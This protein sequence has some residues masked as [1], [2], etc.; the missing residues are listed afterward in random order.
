MRCAV[1]FFS[2]KNRI[3]I[4]DIAKGLVKGI[5]S[6]GH[7]V[8]LIDGYKEQ[9]K[10][11]TMYRYIALGTEAMDFFGKIP[12]VIPKYLTNAGIVAGKPGFAFIIKSF[13][14][15]Q[16]ALMRLMRT[17]EHE[18]MFLRFSEVLESPQHAEAIGEKLHIQQ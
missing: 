18:G 9:E 16:K 8:D 3:K 6:Q 12:E 2:R 13:T 10:K 7:Q 17:M 4:C 5:E 1:I 11:L 15:S 14:G